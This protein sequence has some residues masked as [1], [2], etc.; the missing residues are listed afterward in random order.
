MGVWF[1]LVGM[2]CFFIS[3]L[4]DKYIKVHVAEVAIYTGMLMIAMAALF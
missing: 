1:V 4:A 2:L 3:H